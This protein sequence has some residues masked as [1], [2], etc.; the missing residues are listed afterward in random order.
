VI[1]EESREPRLSSMQLADGS[2]VSKPLE[3]LFPFLERAE[4][5]SNMIIDPLPE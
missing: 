3:D 1:P 4:F 5:L 2:L